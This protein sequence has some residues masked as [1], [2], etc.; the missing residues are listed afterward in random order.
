MTAPGAPVSSSRPAADCR[1][2]CSRC[3]WPRER[4]RWSRRRLQGHRLLPR[5]CLEG[6]LQL[7]F[8]AGRGIGVLVPKGDGRGQA[9]LAELFQL[10]HVDQVEAAA[11]QEHRSLGMQAGRGGGGLRDTPAQ[12]QEP[13]QSGR[14]HPQDGF[15]QDGVR[16]GPA[17]PG[18]CR[19]RCRTAAPDV[20]CGGQSGCAFRPWPASDATGRGAR[21]RPGSRT[22]PAAGPTGPRCR[23]P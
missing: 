11:D 12:G 7:V 18:R 13:G 3:R 5:Q 14:S 17:A 23:S 21:A 9:P 6:L 22:P 2:C 20:P 1:A 19:T 15:V 10:G 16:S 4:M 8:H